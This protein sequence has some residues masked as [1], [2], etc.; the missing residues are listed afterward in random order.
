MIY[1]DCS[2]T[3]FKC[4]KILLRNFNGRMVNNMGRLITKE[5]YLVTSQML[6]ILSIKL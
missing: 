5:V 6:I 1:L 4:G 3:N 2:R